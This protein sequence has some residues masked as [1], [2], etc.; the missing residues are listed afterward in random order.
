MEPSAVRESY[1]DR[2]AEL[3]APY[4]E[5]H[6]SAGESLK[7]GLMVFGSLLAVLTPAAELQVVQLK[8]LA[9]RE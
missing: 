7:K 2:L 9:G 4:L 1:S 3:K 6:S 5:Q 8:Q